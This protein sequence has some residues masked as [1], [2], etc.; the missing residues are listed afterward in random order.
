MQLLHLLSA[1]GEVLLGD[2]DVDAAAVFVRHVDAGLVFEL[3]REVVPQGGRLT[4]PALV[5]GYTDSFALHPYEAEIAAR[6]AIS[7]VAF[8]QQRD[9]EPAA[10]EP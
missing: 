8:V 1:F 10:R 3:D 6:C 5:L 4:R 9:L 7:D 2:A